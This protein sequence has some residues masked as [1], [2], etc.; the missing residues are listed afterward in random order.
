MGIK[1]NSTE[2]SATSR[3]TSGIKGINLGDKDYVVS[4]L[5]IRNEKDC[6]AIFSEEGLS[7]KI[8]LTELISQ[9]RAGKGL[10]CY[11]PTLSSGKVV[12]GALI[13]NE[14]NLLVCGSTNSIC[15]SATDIP[16]LSRI[17]LGNQ[18]LKNGNI[19]SVSKV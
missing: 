11:K 9:K 5:P 10:I 6:L 15:I 2:I 14:D 8:N 7:K 1:F 13:S 16:L 19:V 3:T 12:A 4:A 18:V 17:S